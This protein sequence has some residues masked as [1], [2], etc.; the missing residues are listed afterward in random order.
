MVMPVLIFGWSDWLADKGIADIKQYLQENGIALAEVLESFVYGSFSDRE[1][2][3]IACEGKSGEERLRFKAEW[4]DKKRS[5]LTD[6]G[7]YC[8]KVARQ[9]R[10]VAGNRGPKAGTVQSLEGR[11]EGGR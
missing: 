3:G 2:Y 5:S 9:L 1:L 7:S 11:Q 8:T 6:I 10:A 4:D